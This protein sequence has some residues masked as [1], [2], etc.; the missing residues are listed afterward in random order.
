MKETRYFYDPE[1]SGELPKDEAQHAT[2]VLRLGVGE[3]VRLIDG[4]GKLYTAE[5]MD[6]S[7]HGCRYAVRGALEEAPHWQGHLHIAVAPTKLVDRVEWFAEKAVEMGVDEISF[8]DCRYSERKRINAE[9]IEKILI[10]AMK[11]SHKTWKPRLNDMVRFEDFVRMERC[12]GKFI[13]HCHNAADVGS[14]AEKPFLLN[15]MRKGEDAT[16]LI[17]PEGDFSVDEVRLAMNEGYRAVSLGNS[18][19]R[20]ETAAMVAVNM[21]QIRNMI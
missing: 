5:I 12:G 15:A 17:G 3:E 4:K 20:T 19:L 6:V 13:C 21:M 18:R 11:Q 9:R 2:R 8:L 16:V 7:N 10:S 14:D 1:V